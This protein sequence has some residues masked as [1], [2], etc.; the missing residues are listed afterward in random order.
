MG[1]TT[2]RMER[3]AM[4]SSRERT[5]SPFLGSEGLGNSLLKLS[6]RGG[7]AIPG[8]GAGGFVERLKRAERTART[9]SSELATARDAIRMSLCESM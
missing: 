7:A 6:T 8:A 3:D 1:A 2:N 9:C 4:A 5:K